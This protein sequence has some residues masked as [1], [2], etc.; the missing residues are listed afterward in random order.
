MMKSPNNCMHHFNMHKSVC[1]QNAITGVSFIPKYD[2]HGMSYL[3]NQ[4][5]LVLVALVV[6][7]ASR[8]TND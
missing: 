1:F 3:S 5:P 2:I 4:E 8:E 6:V 7:A